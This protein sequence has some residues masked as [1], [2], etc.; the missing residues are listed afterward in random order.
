MSA[1]QSTPSGS[2]TT[3][4]TRG[5]RPQRRGDDSARSRAPASRA[6]NRATG[7]R[8]TDVVVDRPTHGRDGRGPWHRPGDARLVYRFVGADDGGDDAALVRA[9]AR[10]LARAG[11]AGWGR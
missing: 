2:G 11:A 10:R 9:D 4:P 7:C 8:R 5:A 3:T 1:S 6:G